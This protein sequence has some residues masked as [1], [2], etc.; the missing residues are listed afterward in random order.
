[1]I[2]KYRAIDFHYDFE[3]ID[4]IYNSICGAALR[5]EYSVEI[6]YPIYDSTIFFFTILNYDVRLF[7]GGHTIC[8]SRK[9][10]NASP[11]G[12]KL[13]G[14][15]DAFDMEDITREKKY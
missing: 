2:K 8:W 13:Y 4:A 9:V 5:G 7:S 6:E 10:D 14:Y 3:E 1:M 11:L 12:R 15:Y